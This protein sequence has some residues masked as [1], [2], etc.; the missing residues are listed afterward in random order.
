MIEA[1]RLNTTKPYADNRSRG[2][3]AAFVLI[4]G[5]ISIFLLWLLPDEN[6]WRINVNFY[7][8]PWIGATAI[9]L[10]LPTFY[11][12]YRKKFDIFHPLVH[13]SWAYW[14]PSIVI[15]G[16]FIATDVINPYQMSLLS[17]PETDLI[18]TCVYVMLGYAGLTLGFYLPIGRRLGVY[19]SRRLPAW[20][21]HPD[22]VLLPAMAFFS[23]GLFFYVNSFLAGVVGFS[24]TDTSDAF[25]VVY[26]TLSFLGLEAGFLVAI[27]IFKSENVK[28]EHIIAFSLLLLLLVSRMSLGGN[29]SSMI[30]I[31]ILLAIAFV[32]SGRRMTPITSGAFAV[33]GIL[34]LI[35]GMI[36]GTAFRNQKGTEDRISVEQQIE[37]VSRTIDV[38]STQ[39]TEKVLGEGFY[40]LA[41]RI[42]GIS[43]VAVV[44]SNFE[45]LA[46][47]EA[48]Y[49]LE[50][51]IIKDL[52]IS[53]IP[54]F[55]WNDKP[56][57]SDPRAYSDL[58]FNFSGNSYA[59]TPVGDLIRNYGPIGVPLGMLFVGV[60]L[61][62]TYAMLIENQKVTIGRATA[63]F[64]FLVSLSYEG[65]YS[66]IFIYGWRILVIAFITFI[67]AEFLFINPNNNQLARRWK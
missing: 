30:S 58:Y 44:V 3:I 6:F 40:N 64:M 54:R 62:F 34:A 46:P 41:E 22:Q 16:L 11:L 52:W 24:L 13:A 48:S 49:D 37:T 2:L 36:Y 57:S 33:L 61:R 67:I 21:W 12:F 23:V 60:F 29:R 26:Y 31:V 15:G 10:L 5:T 66:S 51:N 8:L 42:D 50:N 20:D 65:F 17:N 25:S 38:I 1:A 14:F 47:Y 63:Y 55:L 56:P 53:F 18:W 45:R 43:S 35:G 7:L 27:Y 28:L 32:Y 9:V 4:A 19:A 59:I 39:N